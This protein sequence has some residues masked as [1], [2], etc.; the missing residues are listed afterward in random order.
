MRLGW[1]AL[2]IVAK[3]VLLAGCFWRMA[4]RFS[5]PPVSLS[6]RPEYGISDTP[7]RLSIHGSNDGRHLHL[8]RIS[9]NTHGIRTSLEAILAASQSPGTQI[10][11]QTMSRALHQVPIQCTPAQRCARMRATVLNGIRLSI[12]HKDRD[13]MTRYANQSAMRGRD[14]RPR[15]NRY[16]FIHGNASPP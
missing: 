5:R 12:N 13:L 7:A 6:T 11:A 15:S 1:K 14:I 9:F 2:V 4:E 10:K 8:D 16:P 3:L